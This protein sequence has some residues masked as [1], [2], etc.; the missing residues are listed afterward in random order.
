M[1]DILRIPFYPSPLQGAG[2]NDGSMTPV[3]TVDSATA[4]RSYVVSGY[5][6]PNVSR[7]NLVVLPDTYVTKVCSPYV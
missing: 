4:K 7:E 5:L 3:I 6:E 1:F 2:Q